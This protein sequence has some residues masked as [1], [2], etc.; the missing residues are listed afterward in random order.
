MADTRS[1]NP[2]W[3]VLVLL[4]LYIVGG[5]VFS[6]LE[7]DAELDHYAR[8]RRLYDH[9]TE[10]YE[11]R[12]CS[13]PWFKRM[14][15]CQNQKEFSQLLR[16]FF[17]RNGNEMQDQSKWTFFGSAFFVSTLVTTVGYGNFHPRTPGGQLFTVI[18]G[19]IGIPI[20]GYIL[21]YIGRVIVE[22]L[23]PML[24]AADT[25]TRRVVVLFALMAVF[26]LMGTA[27]FRRLE[28]WSWLEACYFS[29]C[30]LMSVGFGDFQPTT[31]CS[32]L[33]A[34]LF[35]FAGLGVAA[36]FMA[37]L[38]V[39]VQRKGET[40][41]KHLSSWYDAVASECGSAAMEGG[42]LEGEEYEV[43]GAAPSR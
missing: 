9:M 7:R 1:R 20:V 42:S 28:G 13:D 19:L 29:V 2:I 33:A 15:F 38:Q 26:V 3:C 32:R 4:I 31:T 41:A 21:A 36:S 35:I 6:W 25:H 27:T 22:K 39:Q 30:T 8:N 14:K 37:L 12:K 24:P 34:T 11:F 5:Q 17:E 18:F 23:M 16:Q 40:F 43:Q 10:M